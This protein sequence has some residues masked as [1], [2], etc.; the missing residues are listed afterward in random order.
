MTWPWNKHHSGIGKWPTDFSCSCKISFRIRIW[1]HCVQVVETP[2]FIGTNQAP[3]LSLVTRVLSTHYADEDVKELMAVAPCRHD[4]DLRGCTTRFFNMQPFEAERP[5]RCWFPH[6]DQESALSGVE[7]MKCME[8][9]VFKRVLMS[10]IPSSHK[11]FH[12][13]LRYLQNYVWKLLGISKSE[14]CISEKEWI[15]CYFGGEERYMH[16]GYD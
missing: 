5:E 16:F 14:M 9:C 8:L 3:C 1:R 11:C 12:L 7:R 2:E 4:T 13:G 15:V 6:P 10:W